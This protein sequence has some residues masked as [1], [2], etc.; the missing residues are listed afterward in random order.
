MVF[1]EEF[2]HANTFV[3]GSKKTVKEEY[4]W[5][6]FNVSLRKNATM[7]VRDKY[8]FK[9]TDGFIWGMVWNYGNE[10]QKKINILYH[11]S[12]EK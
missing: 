9:I 8:D 4:V 10:E 5:S 6:L 2:T 1:G 3:N 11:N 7:F 12:H